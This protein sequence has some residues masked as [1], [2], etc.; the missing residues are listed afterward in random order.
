MFADTRKH[1]MAG[2]EFKQ[3]CHVWFWT[4]T[5][6]IQIHWNPQAAWHIHSNAFEFSTN[7]IN[8]GMLMTS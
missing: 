8:D 7:V 2:K 4:G 1:E 3:M 5:D 6:D